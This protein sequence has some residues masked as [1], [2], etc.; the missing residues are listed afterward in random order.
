MTAEEIDKSN[1]QFEQLK[2]AK[3]K[4][5]NVIFSKHVNANRL[6]NVPIFLML[7][8]GLGWLTWKARRKSN[9]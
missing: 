9:G 5:R 7:A 6:S 3:Q 8:V 4:A 1:E 2:P